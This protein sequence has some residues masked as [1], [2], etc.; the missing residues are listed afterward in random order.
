MYILKDNKINK[1]PTQQ[2]ASFFIKNYAI[3]A[4]PSMSN[5]RP[6]GRKLIAV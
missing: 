6:P 3:D 1:R 2:A 4:R 5:T